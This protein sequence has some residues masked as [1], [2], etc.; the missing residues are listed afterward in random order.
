[1]LEGDARGFKYRKRDISGSGLV[2]SLQIVFKAGAAGK[3]KI[4]VIEKG[5]PVPA[6]PL[7]QPARVQL[8][9]G[10][11]TCWEATYGAPARKNTSGEFKD[12]AD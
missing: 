9:N 7:A 4:G 10:M 11:G 8:V 1:M 2:N 6:L 12:K 3:A 5:G